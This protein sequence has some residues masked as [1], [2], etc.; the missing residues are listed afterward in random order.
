MRGGFLAQISLV[1]VFAVSSVGQGS[2]Q[3]GRGRGRGEEAAARGA[4]SKVQADAELLWP[5]PAAAKAYVAIDGQH[6]KGYVEELAAIARKSRTAGYQQWGRIAGM[7]SGLETQQWVTTKFRQAGLDVRVEEY[8]MRPQSLPQSWEVSVA[9]GGKN[10]KLTSASPII[11]FAQSMPSPEG[12]MDLETVWVGLGMAS[13]FVGKD[14][15]GKAVFIYSIPTPS[16]LIQS[17]GWMGGLARAQKGG[18]KAVMVVLAIPGNMSFVSHVQGLS[19]DSKLP[20]FTV[21]LNDGE[22]VEL[23]NA[24]ASGRGLMTHVSWNVKT[25][26][27]LKAAN[28]IATLPGQTDENIVM[29][30]HTD[31]YF[32]GANDD[33]AGT[34]SL[35]GLAEY[36]AKVPKAQR[37][38]TMY[39]IATPDHHG[40]DAGGR[41]IHD[42]M[43]P[44][45]S[46]AAV[47][48]NAEHVA[49]MEPVWDRPWGSQGRPELIRTNQLGASWWGVNG[50]DRLADIIKNGFA[51]FGVPTQ[52]DEG[53]SAGELRAVQFD[54]PSFYLHNKGVYYHASADTVDVVPATGLRTATQAFAKIFDDINR[55]DLKDLRPLA[56]TPTSG[57]V[58][59]G[60]RRAA[61]GLE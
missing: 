35:V 38:R 6:M 25:F 11:S 29:I 32:E 2:G 42:N 1:A 44:V 45:L 40:G 24:V 49:V 22:S 56:A 53:G 36:Y 34:S 17:E 5:L 37:R 12:N 13:D 52:I 19:N 16:S 61:R 54:A 55:V 58:N 14:V 50:S 57:L 20:V 47:V 15:R 30:A 10:L 43:Q 9:G 18:A 4:L 33:A 41:W 39:F 3:E 46:K 28:V 7:P 51:M 31:G 26:T 59:L 48:L 60:R 23:L 21:G 8:E 27:G